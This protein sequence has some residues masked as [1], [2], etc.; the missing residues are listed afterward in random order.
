MMSKIEFVVATDELGDAVKEDCAEPV[1]DGLSLVDAVKRAER[2][3]I[4]W[5]GLRPVELFDQLRGA[6]RSGRQVGERLAVLRCSCGHR[7]CSELT[8]VVK[9]SGD[10]VV[11]ESF[12]APR[13]PEEMYAQLGPFTF[14]RADYQDALDHP[15]HAQSPARDVRVLQALSDG[16]PEDPSEWLQLAYVEADWPAAGDHLAALLNGLRAR[17]RSGNPIG[18]A[19]AYRWARGLGFHEGTCG[20]VVG[21]V[22]AANAPDTPTAAD[23]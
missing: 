16:E 12:K 21:L 7:D 19:K 18:E 2:R 3:P 15:R 17:R 4:M 14:P 10:S 5:A 9:Q 23:S 11:W 22:R 8:A 13:F 1:I 20:T 6:S